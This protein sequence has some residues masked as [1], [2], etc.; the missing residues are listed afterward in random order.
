M[1][2]LCRRIIRC[3]RETRIFDGIGILLTECIDESVG[4]QKNRTV[5]FDDNVTMIAYVFRIGLPVKMGRLVKV[6]S[7]QDDLVLLLKNVSIGMWYCS[8]TGTPVSP[9]RRRYAIA[10]Q[11]IKDQV[12]TPTP[13]STI[14]DVVQIPVSAEV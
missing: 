6:S 9:L 10:A 8:C 11:M 4:I 3:K 7:D 2:E 14:Q 5:P 1:I 12:R 13:S